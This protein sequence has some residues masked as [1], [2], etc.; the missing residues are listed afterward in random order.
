MCFSI[1][2]ACN[3]N[4]KNLTIILFIISLNIPTRVYNVIIVK[5]IMKM[6]GIPTNFG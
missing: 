6:Y 4:K 2:E 5:A 1:T 3:N